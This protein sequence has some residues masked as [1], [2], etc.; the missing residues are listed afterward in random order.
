MNVC[1]F[2]FVDTEDY[3]GDQEKMSEECNC[4]EQESTSNFVF[5]VT[6]ECKGK[7]AACLH[8]FCEGGQIPTVL[9]YDAEKPDANGQGS[10]AHCEC[11]SDL[12]NAFV[13]QDGQLPCTLSHCTINGTV[14]F[15]TKMSVCY[16]TNDLSDDVSISDL[17]RCADPLN[18]GPNAIS[19]ED[20]STGF[21]Y[22]NGNENGGN[23]GNGFTYG[24]GSSNGNSND[25]GSYTPDQRCVYQNGSNYA[26]CSCTDGS[27]PGVD[28]YD[29]VV[30]QSVDSLCQC[31]ALENGVSDDAVSQQEDSSDDEN[32]SSYFTTSCLAIALSL[33]Y[34]L[35]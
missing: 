18:G 32:Q 10:K 15:G 14:P 7:Y 27:T 5:D 17:C 28:C 29:Q 20:G 21:T 13:C 25:G 35:I 23:D 30:A 16:N 12:T 11:S 6:S 22:G 19:N 4:Q 2:F 24:E 8:E 9:C 34:L 26:A 1:V 33:C 3:H 31:N